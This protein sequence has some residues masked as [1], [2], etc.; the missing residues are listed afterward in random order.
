MR[1][2]LLAGLTLGLAL[3]GFGCGGGDDTAEP[4]DELCNRIEFAADADYQTWANE[5]KAAGL[6]S[7]EAAL[8]RY[9]AGRTMGDDEM[10]AD[11]HADIVRI[12]G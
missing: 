12:C 11:A 3:A 4:Q 9:R 5:A 7:L 10:A 6:E 8:G 1:R 2:P